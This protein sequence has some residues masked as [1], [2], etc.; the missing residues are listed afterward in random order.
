MKQF[1]TTFKKL[2]HSNKSMVYLMW[3]YFVWVI[4]SSTFVNI[5][6]FQQQES[7]Y[8]VLLFNL[9]TFIAS[10]IWFIGIGVLF[11]KMQRSVTDMYYIWY[12]LF[13]LA[14]L[15]LLLFPNSQISTYVFASLYGFA[16]G[17][18]WNA[19]HSQELKNIS[20]INRD[21]YSSSISAGS[22]IISV[23][24][25]LLISWIFVLG[26]LF[27]FDAYLVLFILLPLLYSASFLFIK[28]IPS[29]IPK[30]VKFRDLLESINI[31]KHTFANLYLLCSGAKNW[32]AKTSIAIAS[33]ILLKSEISIWVFQWILAFLASYVVIHFGLKR[34]AWNR[35]NFFFIIC[36]SMV[37]MYL[38]F[39][40]F[41]SIYVFILFSLL[42]LFLFPMYRVSAHTYDLMVMDNSNIWENDFYP[43]ML[44]REILLLISRWWSILF[45]MWLLYCFS[46]DSV[47]ALRVSLAMVWFSIFWELCSI[48]FWERYEKL[49]K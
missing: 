26:I 47:S 18:Y 24:I 8:D 12:I 20:D 29:Y 6:V 14:F 2:P 40:S 30:P 5:Y 34:H 44:W 9:L 22:N 35:F 42:N 25:P 15:S 37:L 31:K 38:V 3:I 1:F 48:Y 7:Y 33:I 43:T 21:F 39:A 32:L 16:A 23:V 11:W 4:V 45:L 13:I 49:S 36:S 46:I 27:S 17:I 28:D 41:F 19:V 10:A